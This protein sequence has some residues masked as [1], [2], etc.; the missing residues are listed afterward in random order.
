MKSL[1]VLDQKIRLLA[2]RH[3]HHVAVEGDGPL[4]V[5]HEDEPAVG[6]EDRVCERRVP[7]GPFGSL[8]CTTTQPAPRF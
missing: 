4:Y 2:Q 1:K 7:E 6:G 3:S 8:R 5:A